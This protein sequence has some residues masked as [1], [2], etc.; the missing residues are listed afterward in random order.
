MMRFTRMISCVAGLA[1]AVSS[2]APVHAQGK[3]GAEFIPG[4]VASIEKDK[5]GKNY[6]MKVTKSDDG[7]EL[8]VSITLRTPVFVTGKGDEGF[9][10]P[11][12]Y[13]ETK[14]MMSNNNLF[15]DELTIFVGP[16]NPAPHVT[17]DKEKPNELFDI[18]GK[19]TETLADKSG[20][21]VQVGNQAQKIG[22]EAGKLVVNVKISDASMIKEGDEVT[23]EGTI[24]KSKKTLNATMVTVVKK[25]P[26]SSEEY[27]A[28]LEDKRK[29][30]GGVAAKTKTGGP[31]GKTEA[32]GGESAVPKS[33]DPFGIL[34]TKKKTP[35]EKAEEKKEEAKKAAEAKAE[36]KDG[37]KEEEK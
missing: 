29:P 17:P 16:Q 11:G 33:S 14:A 35:K 26:I 1:F 20:I 3:K 10:K 6:K 23:V 4:T 28:T 15:A 8:D 31:K 19:I 22:L 27:L 36:A 34:S 37:K 18:G 5:T 2:L 13:L 25:E 21:M 12:L 30:K 9:L 7:E 24:V 32:G